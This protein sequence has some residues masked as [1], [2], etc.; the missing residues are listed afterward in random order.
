MKTDPKLVLGKMQCY[1]AYRERCISDI[2]EKVK[3]YNLV[4]SEKESII[5]S[6]IAENYIDEK[7]YAESFVRSKF[8]YNNWG[9]IKIRY[10]LTQK[11]IST[12][13]IENAL[14]TIDEDAYNQLIEKLMQQKVSDLTKRKKTDV[15]LK[16]VNYLLG[17]GFEKS[18]IYQSIK[19]SPLL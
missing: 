17:K 7:R 4:E 9:R 16:V 18:L 15:P 11:G 5:E 12:S 6:L 19:K 13:T 2:R 1:C 14:K 8:S 3:Q 10:M